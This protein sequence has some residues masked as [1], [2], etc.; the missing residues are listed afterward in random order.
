M[1][2]IN[3]LKNL[4]DLRLDEDLK[5]HTSFS[6]GPKVKALLIP[7]GIHQ[8]QQAVEL[9]RKEKVPFFVMGNGSNLL[10]DEQD[11]DGVVIKTAIP[12]ADYRFEGNQLIASAGASL[13]TLAFQAMQK[14]LGGLEFASGIPGSV[15]GGLY[16]NAGAYKSSLSDILIDVLVLTPQGLALFRKDQLDYGYRH[17]LFQSHRDWII[18]SARFELKPA[19]KQEMMERME[20]RRQRRMAA[21][22]YDQKSAGSVFRNPETIPAWQIVEKLGLRGKKI[23]G[24]MISD[25]H[26]NFIVN[27]EGKASFQDVSDLIDLVKSESKKEFDIDM[28]SEIERVNLDEVTKAK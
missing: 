21:Q 28:I 2:V 1:N 11:F 7:D 10:V 25:K 15:G 12:K 26:A 20:N 16:M 27:P 14:S 5:K 13:I 19:D 23:G 8:M 4:G 9:L 17:S 18:L 24:A 6:I 3:E 22:P